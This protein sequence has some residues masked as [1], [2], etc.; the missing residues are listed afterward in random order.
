MLVDFDEVLV[1]QIII[2]APFWY[3]AL[4]ALISPFM[5]QR[6][7]NKFLVVRPSKV[8]ETLLK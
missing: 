7:K 3:Y 6:T 5:T 1:L 4:N 2:N 8:T